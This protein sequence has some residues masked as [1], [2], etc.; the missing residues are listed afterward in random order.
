MEN[1]VYGNLFPKRRILEDKVTGLSDNWY[2]L[3]LQGTKHWVKFL[4][5]FCSKVKS[6][7]L[8]VWCCIICSSV[9][10]SGNEES[11]SLTSNTDLGI[12]LYCCPMLK[13]ISTSCH[14]QPTILA[15]AERTHRWKLY[16]LSSSHRLLPRFRFSCL[17][18]SINKTFLLVAVRLA[19][20]LIAVVVFPTPPFWFAIVITL[21]ISFY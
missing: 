21:F 20:R 19:A 17:T 13:T 16:P 7:W 1:W 8:K 2:L 5:C 18:T 11:S 3:K 14:L 12:V 6:L 9:V 15:T 4:K 10:H